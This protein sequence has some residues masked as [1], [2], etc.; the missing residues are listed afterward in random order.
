MIHP[1]GVPT[2][3]DARWVGCTVSDDTHVTD[4]VW[5]V[6]QQTQLLDSELDHSDKVLLTSRPV[7]LRGG[8]SAQRR[9][10]VPNVLQ[11]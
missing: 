2:Q 8:W 4:V 11:H 5:L 10:P 6:H 7:A 9:Q 3:Q 1:V